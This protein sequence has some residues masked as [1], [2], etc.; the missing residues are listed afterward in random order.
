MASS[1]GPRRLYN[2]MVEQARPL[3]DFPPEL[4]DLI[5]EQV[6]DAL[7]DERFVLWLEENPPGVTIYRLQDLQT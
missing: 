7:D 3:C 5:R 4:Q 2:Y 6:P 1:K